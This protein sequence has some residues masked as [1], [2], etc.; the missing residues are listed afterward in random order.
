VVVTVG[1]TLVVPLAEVA[2][3]VPG[4]MATLVAPVTDQLRTLLVPETMLVGLATKE[5]M[6]GRFDALAETFTV[7]VAVV[8]P[9]PLLAVSV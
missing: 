6:T 3:N 2:V 4:A 1:L 7:T 8:E 9:P 5:L